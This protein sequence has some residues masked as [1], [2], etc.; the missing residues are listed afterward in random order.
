[1]T[2]PVE[3][4]IYSLLDHIQVQDEK[5]EKM[6]EELRRLGGES[7]DMHLPKL[8]DVVLEPSDPEQAAHLRHAKHK[9]D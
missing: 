7:I 9:G 8:D 6:A 3:K 1:V 5:L 2:D 4:A